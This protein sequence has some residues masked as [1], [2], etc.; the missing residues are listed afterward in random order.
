MA[1]K[2]QLMI[3]AA[4]VIAGMMYTTAAAQMEFF[5]IAPKPDAALVS[6]LTTLIL[7]GA[8]RM[9]EAD[10]ETN[11]RFDAVGALSG[12]HT[13]TPV[14]SDDGVTVCV[15]FA[16]PFLPGERVAVHG[17]QVRPAREVLSY[18]FAVSPMTERLRM[19][20]RF[21]ED[22]NAVTQTPPAQRI[23][24]S[25]AS[26]MDDLPG[27]FPRIH[28]D[29]VDNPSPGQIFLTTSD[30]LP[31]YGYFLMALNNDGTPL[32]YKR[33]P[34]VSYDF[35]VQPNG[36]MTYANIHS[37][38]G[39]TG[40]GRTTHMIMDSTGANIDS[41][42]AGDGY[43][44]DSH[45]FVVLP[46]GHYL[47]HAYDI[48]TIDM[49]TYSAA[50]KTNAIVVGSILQE[51]DAKKNVVFEWRSWDH[52][53]ITD[54]YMSLSGSA[55]DYVHMNAYCMDTDGNIIASL[56]NT[57]EIIKIDRST[58]AILWHLGGKNNQF[59]F[60]GEHAEN[61]PT[62]FTYQHYVRRLPNG[63]LLF[64][65]NGNLH[66]VQYSRA[67][68][69]AIDESAKTATLVWEYRHT[70][71]IFV[72][73]RGS[74]ERLPNGNTLIGWG[75]ASVSGVG[76][77]ALTEVRPDKTIALEMSFPSGMSSYRAVKY[78]WNST[79]PS[80]AATQY[81]VL[82]GNTY[83]F[84]QK[85]SNATGITITFNGTGF[86]YNA[87]TV[88]RYPFAPVYPVFQEVKA[89]IVASV[90]FVISQTGLKTFTAAVAIA[91]TAVPGMT[92]ARNAIVYRRDTEGTGEFLPLPST[93]DSTGTV[94]TISVTKFGE[95][96]VAVPNDPPLAVVPPSAVPREYALQQNFPNPFNPTTTIAFALPEQ[97]YVSIQIYDVTGRS[98]A[99]LV[100]GEREAGS[101]SVAFDA[102][103]ISSGV[104]FYR[105]RAHAVSGAP[106]TEFTQVKKFLLMK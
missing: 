30:S 56:R 104:Y 26:V 101:Y 49:S 14:L 50:G 21:D 55:F 98:I 48:Q 36:S 43:T 24:A 81:D 40:G 54:T 75:A 73:N 3:A 103:G 62:Y 8:T 99:T 60:I 64:F 89:P 52:V 46:N 18:T 42:D 69:Y 59:T 79:G 106:G 95:F 23:I 85:D 77:Q 37:E 33:I 100:D 2:R 67:V 20:G 58:G 6:N 72:P 68:E 22:G 12:M 83:S 74:A 15:R 38:W 105:I 27:D 84:I 47:L 9:S 65:D 32:F 35:N 93:Y 94:L 87:V 70:P 51:L 66:P 29:S 17:A 53:P 92:M 41:V 63:H 97:S 86:G 90:R 25:P 5:P 88:K 13:G 44:S 19:E 10:I 11:M 57:S 34:Y 39:Y 78:P 45:E 82:P 102:A 28:V 16:S 31:G 4:A 76:K 61:A 91:R 96:I 80:A 7:R 1:M 71:D